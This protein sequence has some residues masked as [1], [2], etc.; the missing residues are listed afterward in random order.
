MSKNLPVRI[1]LILLALVVA[2]SGYTQQSQITAPQKFFGFQLGADRKLA[3]WDKIVEYFN[4]LDKESPK[5]TVLDI[6]PTTMGNPFLLAYISSPANLSRLEQL[7]QI[8]TKLSDPRGISEAEIKKL[9]IDGK[10]V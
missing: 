5:I 3:R 6:G 7:R 1:V 4:L 2:G 10:V 8:N 9:L